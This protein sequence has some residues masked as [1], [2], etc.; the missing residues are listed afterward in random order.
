MYGTRDDDSD[1]DRLDYDVWA[2]GYQYNF[3][4]RTD[5]QVL[6]RDLN[7]DDLLPDDKVFAV[8]LDHAF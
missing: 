1:L 5:V 7:G 4:K 6:Y 2:L 8:Q 3:S